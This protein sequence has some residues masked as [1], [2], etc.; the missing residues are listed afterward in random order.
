MKKLLLTLILITSL[1]LPV[2][3]AEGIAPLAKMPSLSVASIGGD[4]AVIALTRAGEQTDA[5]ENY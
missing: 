3:A 2:F 5:L 1:I 4:W